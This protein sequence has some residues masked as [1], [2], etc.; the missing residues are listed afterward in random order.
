MLSLLSA[1]LAVKTRPGRACENSGHLSPG[2]S[3]ARI[4]YILHP[5]QKDASFA[6]ADY[7]QLAKRPVAKLE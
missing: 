5:G 6:K 7:E 1:A 3:G 4:A 2:L